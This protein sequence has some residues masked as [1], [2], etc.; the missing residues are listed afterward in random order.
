MSAKR[1]RHSRTGKPGN[2]QPCIFWIVAVLLFSTDCNSPQAIATFAASSEQA[3][4]Q[5]PPLFADLYGACGRIH[6][7]R[8]PIRPVF[9]G[10]N[11]K[12]VNTR[13][14]QSSACA[15]FQAEAGALG[16]ASATL[17]AYFQAMQEFASS[18]TSAVMAPSAAASV[19]AATTANLT[20]SQIQ[21]VGKLAGLVAQ[22]ASEHYQRSHLIRYLKE[23][24]S[25]VSHI[26]EAFAKIARDYQGMLEE[27]R[28]ELRA[29]YQDAD[30]RADPAVV[31]LLDRAY[32]EDMK[33]I[34]D[35]RQ[36]AEAYIT[37]LQQISQ[38]HHELAAKASQ[39]KAKEVGL[40]LEPYVA[41]LQQLVPQVQRAFR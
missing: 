34:D 35:R 39:L 33:E 13:E 17:S 8:E 32:T 21:A 23:A 19:Q 5:G 20:A 38:G 10:E 25:S 12:Q 2:G 36:G 15:S 11:A 3:I 7:Y 16:A 24:D 30:G 18:K 31:L 22:A 9:I 14:P 1:A 27:E 6:F 26:T 28:R 40:A 29:R 37:A 41:R 4:Q